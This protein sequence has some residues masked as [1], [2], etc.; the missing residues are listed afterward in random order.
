VE[1]ITSLHVGGAPQ[2]FQRGSHPIDGIF[3]APQLLEL[4]AGGY[5]NFGDA[6]LSDHWA[7]WLDL[8][9]PELCLVHQEA[10]TKPHVQ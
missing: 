10:H 6:I 2:T 9:L 7:V 4:A 3:V 8:H 1:A 5:L